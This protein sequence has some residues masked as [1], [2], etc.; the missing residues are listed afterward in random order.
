MP[1]GGAVGVGGVSAD[2]AGVDRQVNT[3]M[4]EQWEGA[5]PGLTGK[6]L[7]NA[8]YFIGRSPEQGSSGAL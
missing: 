3:D 8:M 5:Y 6:L 1:L 2:V 7:K 4:Q